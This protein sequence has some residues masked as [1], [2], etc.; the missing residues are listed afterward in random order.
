MRVAT[1][2]DRHPVHEKC[3]V[4][5]VVGIETA[6]EILI[7]LDAPA[8]MVDGDKSWHE[9]QDVSGPGGQL[10]LDVFGGNEKL[11]GGLIEPWQALA[12]DDHIRQAGQLTCDLNGSKR[13]MGDK[14]RDAQ[15]QDGRHHR[16]F[17]L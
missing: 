13:P 14:Q 1:N 4:S 7:C 10:Q 15:E 2:V 16:A 11:R 3:H 12:G 6:Q 17:S 8:R 9:T 5:A